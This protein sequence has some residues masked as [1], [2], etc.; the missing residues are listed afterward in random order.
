MTQEGMIKMSGEEK[1][2]LGIGDRVKSIHSWFGIV[3][4]ETYIVNEIRG[5]NVSLHRLPG[6][7]NQSLFVHAGSS[8]L[9][10]RGY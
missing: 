1:Q 8:Q 6:E 5:D 4:G 3:K 2:E 9:T 10:V 7:F